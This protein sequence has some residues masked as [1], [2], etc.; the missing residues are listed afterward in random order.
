M[1]PRAVAAH[2]LRDLD[3]QEILSA[4]ARL[5]SLGWS[6]IT[7]L[8]RAE[9]LAPIYASIRLSLVALLGGLVA[10][11]VFGGLIAR[12]MIRPIE[13]LSL[14]GASERLS[15]RTGIPLAR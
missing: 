2:A 14:S 8:P 3:G 11:V 15:I 10:A 5:P 4:H 1:D 12:H 7:E 9:V 6:V 13:N